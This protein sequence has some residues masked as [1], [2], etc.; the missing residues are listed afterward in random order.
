MAPWEPS[1]STEFREANPLH[2]FMRRLGGLY[3]VSMLFSVILHPL[4]K[5]LYRLSRGRWTVTTV[6]A[7]LP[8]I[9]L[10]TTGA[11]TG[12]SRTLPV[13]GLPH[14]DRLAGVGSNYGKPH[15]PA[16]YH[17]LRA[18]PDATVAVIGGP[19]R[20]VH[21][22]PATEEERKEIW[23]MALRTYPGWAGYERRCVNRVFPV[24][25]LEP[26]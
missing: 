16:W 8:L 7:G 21:A 6:L 17:N 3:P 12:K 11:K 24:L 9:L 18:H 15:H 26:A 14:G 2:R 20:I 10:T 5:L 25:V 4:D 19:T 13:F 1:M 23:E 22:R